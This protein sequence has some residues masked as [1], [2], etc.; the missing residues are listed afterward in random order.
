[1][2]RQKSQNKYW[3]LFAHELE[4]ILQA[5]G[6]SFSS[7]TSG[8][9]IHSEKVRRLKLSLE[10]PKFHL[11]SPEELDHVTYTFKFTGEEQLRLRAA[12]LATAIEETLM[13]R[14]DA[15]NALRAAEEI[16]PIIVKALRER[17]GQQHGMAVT[18]RDFLMDQTSID[19]ILESALEQFD[20]AMI[21]LHLGYH[22]DAPAE[23]VEQTCRARDGFAAALVTLEELRRKHDSLTTSTIWEM[24]YTEVQSGLTTA[25]QRLT[26][27]GL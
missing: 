26:Q 11:L 8:A 6:L 23:R 19:E 4:V 20:Q 7:L 24:W 5:H 25:Q 18:R 15:D 21:A 1:M 3:N 12:I 10:V 16:F 27:L 2:T 9:Q 17:V 13:N 14:I 22:V